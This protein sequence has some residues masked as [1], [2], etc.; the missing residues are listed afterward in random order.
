MVE[1][2]LKYFR[3]CYYKGFLLLAIGNKSKVSNL[4]WKCTDCMV[5]CLESHKHITFSPFWAISFK[6]SIWKQHVPPHHVS[7]SRCYIFAVYS[8]VHT[9]SKCWRHKFATNKFAA[10]QLCSTHLRISLRKESYDIKFTSTSFRIRSRYEPGFR[11]TWPIK[12]YISIITRQIGPYLYRR[13]HCHQILSNNHTGR[14][15]AGWYIMHS[16]YSRSEMPDHT[17][18]FLRES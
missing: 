8:P 1:E 4:L 5:V 2:I 14:T 3:P 12:M 17:R 6:T 13:F 7:L 18:W 9:C 10:V 15:L 11:Q 16:H